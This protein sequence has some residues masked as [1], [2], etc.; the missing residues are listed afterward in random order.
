MVKQL[1]LIL[2]LL[3]PV[4]LIL[5]AQDQHSASAGSGN[6][7]GDARITPSGIQQNNTSD[8]KSSAEKPFSIQAVYTTTPCSSTLASIDV[9]NA[10]FPLTWYELDTDG[11]R[12]HILF[13]PQLNY[14]N[15]HT[16]YVVEDFSQHTDT[17][18]I[19]FE[20]SL[21]IH[22]IF[23]NPHRKNLFI[24]YSAMET[25]AIEVRIYDTAGRQVLA[26]DQV[27]SPGEQQ[28]AFNLEDL[29]Q[30]VYFFSL[31]GLCINELKKIVHLR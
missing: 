31:N 30:G 8:Q 28:A 2:I 15:N 20:K 10:H 23:P 21:A 29:Q 11:Q 26:Y 6:S 25:T 16:T 17:I 12:V 4:S 13:N 3:F 14:F 19:E 9:F 22:T 7:W 27:L 24:H 5:K 18:F 1:L